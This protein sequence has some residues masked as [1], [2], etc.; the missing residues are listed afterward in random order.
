MR[1]VRTSAGKSLISF[2]S[3]ELPCRVLR[4]KMD[5]ILGCPKSFCCFIR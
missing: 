3:E 2:L 4:E 5:D 1:T